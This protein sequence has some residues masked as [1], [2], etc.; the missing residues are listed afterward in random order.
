[1]LLLKM[2]H[3]SQ[4]ILARFD[5]STAVYMRIQVFWDVTPCHRA[6]G[7]WFFKG[8]IFLSNKENR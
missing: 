6:S 2:Q 7:F 5:V 8:T 4:T 3:S 1:M